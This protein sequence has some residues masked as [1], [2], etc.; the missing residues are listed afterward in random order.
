ME[1]DIVSWIAIVT[2]TFFIVTGI[3]LMVVVVYVV[4]KFLGE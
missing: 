1:I 2:G 4:N 3:F